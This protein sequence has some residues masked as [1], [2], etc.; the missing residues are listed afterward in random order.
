[1]NK[2]F[3]CVLLLL[4]IGLAHCLATD[5]M[6]VVLKTDGSTLSFVLSSKP[7]LTFQN[8]SL[9]IVSTGETT[10][11][12]LTD[13][14]NFHFAEAPTA[15]SDVKQNEVR[16]VRCGNDELQIYGANVNARDVQ[17]F[18]VSGKRI[19]ATCSQINGGV[20]VSLQSCHKGISIVKTNNSS[21]IKIV[22]K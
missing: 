7:E 18:D 8:G 3:T 15:I 22:K 4:F 1:M 19:N 20:S 11:V 9:Q 2:K 17:V 12:A 21:T 16:I 14:V 13:V 10:T 5:N 6:L